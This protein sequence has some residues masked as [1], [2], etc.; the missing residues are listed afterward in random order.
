MIEA[1][2]DKCPHIE[3]ER[4]VLRKWEERDLD[5]LVEMNA[6]PLVM[7]FFPSVMS[8]QDSERMF[9]RLMF[10]QEKYGF[11]TPVVEERATGRFLGLC[12]LGIP[13]Y[14]E[15]L[16]FDPCV[17]IG[18]RLIPDAW[19]RG[20]AQE[21]SRIWL[22]FGFEI[23]LLDEIVSFTAAT[24]WRSEKVMQRL[25]MVRHASEDF[26]HPL[27]EEGHP[28]KRHVLYRLSKEQFLRQ[29]HG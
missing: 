2:I 28:L 22:G 14:P 5:G 1:V 19:G 12:G 29:S 7:E 10:K 16:P 18:W 24:N 4:L 8:R 15:P 13:S 17:E 3:T 6:D 27:I 11:G 26:N 25:G 21:A 9:E 23:L 20:I